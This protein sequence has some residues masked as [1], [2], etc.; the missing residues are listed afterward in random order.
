MNCDD[1]GLWLQAREGDIPPDE[2]KALRAHLEACPACRGLR[3]AALGLDQSLAAVGRDLEGPFRDIRVVSLPPRGR[4]WARMAAAAALLLGV[5][6]WLALRPGGETP[7]GP[8]PS[9][10]AAVAPGSVLPVSGP[11]QACL[12]D[13]EGGFGRS[14]RL[15]LRKGGSLHLEP[16]AVRLLEG[17]LHVDAPEE[18]VTV[19]FGEASIK[20]TG[21]ACLWTEGREERA[22][23]LSWL[24][25]AHADG[26]RILR[27]AVW[28][29]KVEA[30]AG[31]MGA[32]G[33]RLIVGEGEGRLEADPAAPA[34][35]WRGI[36]GWTTLRDE[37][38][39]LSDRAEDLLAPPEGGYVLEMLVRK[40]AAAEAAV[41]VATASGCYEVPAGVHLPVSEGWAL[42]RLEAGGGWVRGTVGGATFIS[43]PEGS[44]RQVAQRAATSQ[45]G[46]RAWGGRVEAKRIRWRPYASRP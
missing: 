2:G 13:A 34:L 20:V 27:I 15:A 4:H 43:C 32:G 40:S 14:A 35:A 17:A 29:G 8:S 39:A 9:P 24:R 46:L 25:E 41:R 10:V 21:E 3:E 1:A 36:P 45:A 12:A 28:S 30:G 6:A 33:A 19:R 31:S 38:L 16:G 26:D 5:G 23:S 44:L 42:L 11:F 7:S 37:T 18:A 22:A